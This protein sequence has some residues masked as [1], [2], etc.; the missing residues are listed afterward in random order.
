MVTTSNSHTHSHLSLLTCFASSSARSLSRRLATACSSSSSLTFSLTSS[1]TPSSSTCREDSWRSS[2]WFSV[3]TFCKLVRVELK[4]PAIF[5]MLS[6]S[7]DEVSSCC[8]AISWSLLNIEEGN[9]LQYE[10]IFITYLSSFF[11]LVWNCFF[12]PSDTSS[13]RARSTSCADRFS[14]C[15]REWVWENCNSLSREMNKRTVQQLL[16][17]KGQYH[18]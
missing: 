7:L 12:S 6:C 8:S 4:S 2:V 14:T 15:P 13:W 10:M 5:L 11:T 1:L 3:C 16:K 17:T 18:S 9:R